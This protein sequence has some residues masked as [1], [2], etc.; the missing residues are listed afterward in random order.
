MIE[1]QC[2]TCGKTLRIPDEYRGITGKCN[3]CDQLV[4]VP[5]D[6]YLTNGEPSDVTLPGL[7]STD[8]AEPIVTST[9]PYSRDEA[10]DIDMAVSQREMA[11][12]QKDMVE[13]IKKQTTT[14]RIACGC[15]LLFLTAPIWIAGI[16]F[17]VTVGFTGAL[18]AIT[19]YIGHAAQP[20]AQADPE[21][22]PS[23]AV[24]SEVLQPEQAAVESSENLPPEPFPPSKAVYSD[25]RYYHVDRQCAAL[26]STGTPSLLSAALEKG[27]QPCL[28]CAPGQPPNPILPPEDRPVPKPIPQRSATVS[29]K[30][31][32]AETEESVF[33]G[34][35]GERYHRKTCVDLHGIVDEWSLSKALSRGLTACPKCRSAK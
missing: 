5:G 10:L 24:E 32:E 21:A 26:I 28:V 3:G 25:Q 19:A 16:T 4:Y 9:R 11:R 20:E 15:L 18:A 13:A 12:A 30:P 35:V 33:V 8:V 2:P 34:Q 31:A 27:K 6:R 23:G 22:T 7:S 29:E 17:F 14:H 1:M